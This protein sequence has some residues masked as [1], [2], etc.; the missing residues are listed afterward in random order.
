MKVTKTLAVGISA[1]TMLAA[2]ASHASPTLTFIDNTA[3][4][5]TVDPFGGFD[6]QS[7]ATAVS[8]APVYDGTTVSTTTY[9]ASAEAIKLSD[10]TSNSPGS[11]NTGYEFTIRA[12]INET[13]T[14]GL[15]AGAPFAST[16]LQA[17]FTA[18]GGSFDIFYDSTPDAD[19]INGTGFLNGTNVVS[20]FINP[21]IAGSFTV[22]GPAAGIGVFSFAGGVSFTNTDNSDDAYFSPALDLSNG[23]ATLQIGGTNTNWTPPTAWVDGGGIPAGAL[24]FQADGNQTFTAAAVPEPGSLALAGLSLAALGLAR[25][26]RVQK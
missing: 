25:R 20:G 3:T 24:V 8:G 1:L 7:N 11:I 22:T 13:T 21:G 15:W 6:W 4:V 10:G 2:A 17:T 19:L 9:L 23:V 14:C 18:V 26:R 16:C 12:I 5:R